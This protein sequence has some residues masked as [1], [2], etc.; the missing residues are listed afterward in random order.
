MSDTP[1]ASNNLPK[2]EDQ[3][4]WKIF[5]KADPKTAGKCKVLSKRWRLRLM[6]PLFA[7]HNY[8]ENKDKNMQ[9]VVGLAR[10]GRGEECF[11]MMRVDMQSRLQGEGK[12][13]ESF[14]RVESPTRSRINTHDLS[15]K[16][17]D[18]AVSLHAFGHIFDT[19]NYAIVQVF[20]KT[21]AER[22]LSWCLYSSL[23][24]NWEIKGSFEGTF[25]KL[26][27]T[28]VVHKGVVYWIGWQGVATPKP[29][30]IVSF[31]LR[32]RAFAEKDIPLRAKTKF[33][34]L[35]I[36][37]DETV[38]DVYQI[39]RTGSSGSRWEKMFR[40]PHMGVPFTQ[41]MFVGKFLLNVLESRSGPYNSNDA[42]RT[43]LLIAK[44]DYEADKSQN[45]L[46]KSW[47]E[48]MHLRT[49]FVYCPGIYTVE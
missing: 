33:H 4:L 26:G 29:K 36:I 7:K 49:V 24:K 6:A 42:E 16:H 20:K 12:V 8:R 2:L 27:P 23:A 41:T 3:I 13:H 48:I 19:L 14:S 34:T 45:L 1:Q 18:F 32:N 5:T 21:Y 47:G 17:K 25:E 40:I 37:K 10:P 43:D 44:H 28:Y 15:S 46:S 30:S 39:T 31:N 38:V 35:N 9:V 11:S 22:T